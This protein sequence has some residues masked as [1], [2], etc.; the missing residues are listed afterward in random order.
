MFTKCSL[1]GISGASLLAEPIFSGVMIV[2]ESS[3]NVYLKFFLRRPKGH[4]GGYA[5]LPH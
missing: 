5:T 4:A 1:Y 2:V 3:I